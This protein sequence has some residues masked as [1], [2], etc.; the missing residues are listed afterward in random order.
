MA[1][2][3]DASSFDPSNFTGNGADYAVF[4]QIFDPLITIMADGSFEGRLA[5]SWTVNEDSTEF[6]FKLRQGIKFSNGDD[7]TAK[8]VVYSVETF[9]T[10]PW[11]SAYFAYLESVEA[12]GDYEVTFKMAAPD[13]TLLYNLPMFPIVGEKYHSTAADFSSA[14]VGTGAFVLDHYTPASE[15]VLKANENYFRGPAQIK[16]IT[17]KIILDSN[18]SLISLQAG[19]VDFC[20]L[21]AANYENA[22]GDDNLV[23]VPT[24]LQTTYVTVLNTTKAPFDN[25]KVRQAIAYALDREFVVD[26]C[27]AGLGEAAYSLLP[28]YGACYGDAVKVDY[29]YNVEKAK[30]LLAEA[31]I[32][33]P[34]TIADIQTIEAWKTRAVAMQGCLKDIGIECGVEVLEAAK[35]IENLMTGSFEVS[36]INFYLPSM[37]PSGIEHFFTSANLGGMNFS[38]YSNPE[39][40]ELFEK[41]KREGDPTKRMEL[42]AKAYKILTEDVPYVPEY[43]PASFSAMDK[44]LKIRDNCRYNSDY[45]DCYW[46]E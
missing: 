43:Y 21:S 31:G 24:D 25:V 42:Y 39:V 6:V 19:D 4:R 46:A 40:D 41:G 5:E 16:T 11:Y 20:T 35:L 33:T 44:N 36:Q 38:R 17:M 15:I 3:Q 27:E 28:P 45:Y 1:F 10:V 22:A 37:D 14:P 32:T 34:I 29:K 12:T 9:K 2:P 7:F 13:A 26:A 30:A 23:I 8:D 18:T